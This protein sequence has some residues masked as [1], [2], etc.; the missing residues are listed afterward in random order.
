MSER[1]PV[2]EAAKILGMNPQGVRQQMKAGI[3]DIGRVVPPTGKKVNHEY[4]VYINKLN[5]VLVK[6]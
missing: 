1:I 6:V 5:K 2:N 3:L 4:H